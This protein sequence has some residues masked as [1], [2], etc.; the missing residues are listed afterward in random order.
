MPVEEVFVLDVAAAH[1]GGL[2]V[3]ERELPVVPVRRQ[4]GEMVVQEEG[5]LVED[6]HLRAQGPEPLQRIPVLLGIGRLVQDDP[7][8]EPF[9]RPRRQ[10]SRQ[11]GTASVQPKAVRLHVDGLLRLPELVLEQFPVL[12]P[13]GD[14]GHGIALRGP[15][16]HVLFHE[17]GQLLIFRP[18]TRVA[19]RI[20]HLGHIRRV[21]RRTITAAGQQQA[22]AKQ[23]QFR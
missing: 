11:H 17:G 3:Q 7:D 23:N 20:P 19:G 21:H 4:A 14:E 16:V 10:D 13:V 2:P 6:A 1:E 15:H 9:G 18:Y 12:R 5:R 22:A 8:V